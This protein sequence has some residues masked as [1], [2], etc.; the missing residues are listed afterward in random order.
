MAVIWRYAEITLRVMIIPSGG[1]GI[2]VCEQLFTVK[3]MTAR[4]S[5]L[6]LRAALNNLVVVNVFSL[7]SVSVVSIPSLYGGRAQSPPKQRCNIPA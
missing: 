1:L 6:S 2:R 5:E 4:N 3:W 7:R